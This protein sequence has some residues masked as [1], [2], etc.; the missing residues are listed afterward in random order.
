[1]ADFKE[2][3]EVRRQQLQERRLK[4]QKEREKHMKQMAEKYNVLGNEKFDMAYE[5]A[6]SYGHS[7]GYDEV[8]NYFS[9]I[10]DLIK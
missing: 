2:L 1:M 4:A 9:D 6:W 5:L 10:V 3:A 8:E 7:A